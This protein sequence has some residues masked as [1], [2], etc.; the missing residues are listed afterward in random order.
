MPFG[1]AHGLKSPEFSFFKPKTYQKIPPSP[2]VNSPLWAYFGMS[3]FFLG[4]RISNQAVGEASTSKRQFMDS[5]YI[6]T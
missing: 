5:R 2:S 6:G 1:S 4:C 3:G